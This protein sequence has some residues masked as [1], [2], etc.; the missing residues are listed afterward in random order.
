MDW[1]PLEPADAREAPVATALDEGELGW[2]FVFGQ[3]LFPELMDAI[4][5]SPVDLV[6][7]QL[8]YWI[9]NELFANAASLFVSYRCNVWIVI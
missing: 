7:P 3:P 2:E 5:K 1:L 6:L 4:L 8:I 9:S